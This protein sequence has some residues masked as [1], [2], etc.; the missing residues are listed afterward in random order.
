MYERRRRQEDPENK[1]FDKFCELDFDFWIMTCGREKVHVWV[2]H[3]SNEAARMLA[4]SLVL[5]ALLTV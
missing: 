5:V 3:A 1:R 4:V 2:S